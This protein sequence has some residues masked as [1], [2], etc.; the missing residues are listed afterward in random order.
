MTTL[1]ELA[2]ALFP[3]ARRVGARI[4]PASE[5]PIAWVRV[6]RARVPAFDALEPGD[7]AI[8]PEATL[9][10]VAPGR[11]D[12]RQ[13]VEACRSARVAGLL[14]IEHEPR[15][16]ADGSGSA[17]SD[18][19]GPFEDLASELEAAG[20][21]AL[22]VA[23]GDAGRLER[24]IIGYLVTGGAELERQ[25]AALENHLER[26]ALEGGG[27]AALVGAIAAQ[28]GRA[29]ALEG[30]RGDPLAVHAPAEL[31]DSEIGRASCRERV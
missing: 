26:V 12:R 3:G 8:V 15:P 18:N 2:G 21:P 29:V 19:P 5:A 9:G 17:G 14:L 4:D 13:L 7:L 10:V 16:G 30:R 6:M 24:S 1:S 25:A 22:R 20:L 11:D 28:F 23:P 27:P 31:P